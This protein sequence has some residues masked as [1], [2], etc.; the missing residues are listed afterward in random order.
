MILI[1]KELVFSI[2]TWRTV[3]DGQTLHDERDDWYIHV[4][5]EWS[6]WPFMMNV[7]I[8]IFTSHGNDRDDPSWWTWWLVYSRH[9]G[10]IGMTLHDERDDWYI[11]VTWE[12]SGWPFMMNVMIGIFTSHGNDRDDPSWWTWWLVYSRHMG[13]IGMTL[14]DERDDWYIHVTWEWS[15][16]PFMMNVMIGIFTSHGNNRDDPSWWTWWLVYS[17]HMGMI[18]MTLHDERD[19]WYIHVTWEWS[20]W[21]FMMNV[22]IGIFTSH[23]NDRDDP[24][25]W[26]WWLVYS[27]HM[28]MIGMTLHDERDDWYI[29]V[30]WEWSG[31]PFMMNVMIGIFTSHGNDRDVTRAQRVSVAQQRSATYVFNQKLAGLIQWLGNSLWILCA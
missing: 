24:S 31:W 20:G 6:G 1:L 3:F 23:G 4:T 26:T 7:M 25:W 14:H 16:W 13:M 11:H 27:R 10:M 15:G 9:M 21:P 19:D 5:W 12:W 22:M 17:R 2:W 8:G 28:G 30:T 18:G 29:H